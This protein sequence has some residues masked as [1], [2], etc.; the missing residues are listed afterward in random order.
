MGNSVDLT[1]DVV[2]LDRVGLLI[3]R[4]VVMSVVK[5]A[6]VVKALEALL[7]RVVG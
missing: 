4:G 1:V 2:I 3:G 7:A 6:S 5:S